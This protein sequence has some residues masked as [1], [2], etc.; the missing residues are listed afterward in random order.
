M[1]SGE[2]IRIYLG[3]NLST[4]AVRADSRSVKRK[5]SDK[6]QCVKEKRV[7]HFQTKLFSDESIQK[8]RRPRINI[9][10]FIYGDIPYSLIMQEEYFDERLSRQ[11]IDDYVVQVHYITFEINLRSIVTQ[12]N[13]NNDEKKYKTI[14]SLRQLFLRYKFMHYRYIHSACLIVIR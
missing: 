7:K 11:Y 6:D 4:A 10:A 1:A 13:V 14:G 9:A 3:K 8:V 5:S 2:L 12:V